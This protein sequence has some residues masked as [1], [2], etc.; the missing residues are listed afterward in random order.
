MLRV[1]NVD[2]YYGDSHTLRDLS[3][4]LPEGEVLCLMG[5]NGVGKTTLLNAIMG[6]LPLRRGTVVLND[7]T[8]NLLRPDQRARA[9]LGYV[10]QGRMIFPWLTVEENLRV[11]LAGQPSS[12]P[13]IPAYVYDLFPILKDLADRRGGD[14]SGGQQQQLAIAR[15]L[16]LK[17]R[18]LLLDEPCEGVQPNLVQAIGDILASLNTEHGLTVLLVEQRLAFARRLAHRFAILDRG[19]CV[20]QGSI[21]ALSDDLVDEHLTV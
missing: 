16:V 12:S 8:L 15:A 20:A 11:A 2:Q 18:V 3:I 5:R 19:S 1:Q 9:G 14:L 17:P 10:P 6:L 13:A 7:T 21:D 4:E